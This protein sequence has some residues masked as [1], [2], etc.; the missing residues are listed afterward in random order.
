MLTLLSCTQ[1]ENK[2]TYIPKPKPPIGY[3]TKCYNYQ[4]GYYEYI[5]SNR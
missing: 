3:I 2:I 1:N 4:L 5:R